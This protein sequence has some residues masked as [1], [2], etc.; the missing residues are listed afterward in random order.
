VANDDNAGKAGFVPAVEVII[1]H[2]APDLAVSGQD[3]HCPVDKHLSAVPH[4][5][6][7]EEANYY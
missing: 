4:V 3:L 5:K 2:K 6:V 1:P 7:A